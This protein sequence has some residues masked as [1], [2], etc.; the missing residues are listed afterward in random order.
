MSVRS[1]AS[2][3]WL[4]RYVHADMN[5]ILVN[6]ISL[7]MDWP[8]LD[9]S[10]VHVEYR[11]RGQTLPVVQAH[12]ARDEQRGRARLLPLL[13]QRGRRRVRPE[14]WLCV[15]VQPSLRGFPL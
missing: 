13:L 12:R 4:M 9:R 15:V 3:C 7:N 11:A 8:G 2:S 10:G 6:S 14:S 5:L 1:I